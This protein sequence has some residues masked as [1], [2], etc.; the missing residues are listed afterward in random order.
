MA[1][2]TPHGQQ[3]AVLPP[4]IGISAFSGS[5]FFP[6]ALWGDTAPPLDRGLGPANP[7]TISRE[8]TKP[9]LPT[10]TSPWP[11]HGDAFGGHAR[12]GRLQASATRDPVWGGSAH[13]PLGP[14]TE[15]PRVS[16]LKQRNVFKVDSQKGDCRIEG[17]VRFKFLTN[18]FP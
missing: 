18:H 15:G 12:Q 17:H 3:A 4:P 11:G 9:D 10:S 16:S 5:I 13:C 8:E 14:S 2:A 7:A 1:A 6:R